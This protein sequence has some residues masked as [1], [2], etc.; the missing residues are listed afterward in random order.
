MGGVNGSAIVQTGGGEGGGAG[1]EGGI[2]V[3]FE[4]LEPGCMNVLATQGGPINLLVVRWRSF[5]TSSP[6]P[7]SPLI[8]IS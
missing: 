6:P 7:P 2:D 5:Y 1:R 4:A 3:R 8:S